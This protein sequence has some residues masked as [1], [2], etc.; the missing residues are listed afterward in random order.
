MES[1][2]DLFSIIADTERIPAE[3]EKGIVKQIYKA[4]FIFDLDNYRGITLSCNV[5][6]VFSKVFE[7][8]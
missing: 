4:D 6:K 1:L 2:V 7:I 8:E 5:Y 3:W